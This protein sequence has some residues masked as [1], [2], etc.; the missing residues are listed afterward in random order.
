VIKHLKEEEEK[1]GDS[2]LENRS[3]G[4][5]FKVRLISKILQ[6]WTVLVNFLN[7]S[8]FNQGRLQE[9]MFQ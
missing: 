6:E 1:K 8:N 4:S 2:P 5:S 3:A 7:P 9:K